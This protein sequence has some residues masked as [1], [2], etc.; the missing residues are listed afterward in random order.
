MEEKVRR[1]RSPWGKRSVSA[2]EIDYC[3]GFFLYRKESARGEKR[4]SVPP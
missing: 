4:K 3:W 1:R 2:R